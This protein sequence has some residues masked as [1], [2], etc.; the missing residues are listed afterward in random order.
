[1]RLIFVI[2]L[3]AMIFGRAAFA[4]VTKLDSKQ[5]RIIQTSTFRHIHSLK[6]LPPG[7]VAL[8]ADNNGKLADPDQKWQETDVIYDKNLPRNRLIWAGTSKDYYVL[9]YEKGGFAPSLHVVLIK[10]DKVPRILWHGTG[11]K[12]RDFNEFK[13]ALEENKLDDRLD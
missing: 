8:C 7:V 13:K 9:H 12:L 3:M 10:A 11:F 1:M 6:K 5:R 4:K 2:F